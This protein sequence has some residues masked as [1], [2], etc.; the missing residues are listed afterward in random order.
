[1]SPLVKQL[2]LVA[3]SVGAIIVGLLLYTRDLEAGRSPS[4]QV[5]PAPHEIVEGV[6][7]GNM[8]SDNVRT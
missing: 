5:V 3:G 6:A 8:H 2:L 1:M 4:S 7:A